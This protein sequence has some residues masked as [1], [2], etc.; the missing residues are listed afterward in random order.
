MKKILFIIQYDSFI[1]TLIPVINKLNENNFEIEIIL[2]KSKFYKKNWISNEILCLFDNIKNNTHS[3]EIL[4]IYKT[5]KKVAENEYK[6]IIIGTTYSKL[7]NKINLILKKN[8]LNSKLVSGYV[9]ALL[10][11][12]PDVFITGLKRRSHS[13]LIWTPGLDSKELIL[14]TGII[15]IKNTKV[16]DTG[17]PRFDKLYLIKDEIQSLN[18]NNIVF[19]EQPT[20]PKTKLERTYLVEKLIALAY[21]NPNNN[22]IIKPRFS[23]K[24]GHAH[25]P[26]YLIQDI[27]SKIKNKPKNIFISDEHIYEL[28]KECKLALTISSTAG[29]ES[30][31][32]NIPTLFINDFCNNIN[33]YGSEDFKKFNA[34]I[35]FDNLLSNKLPKINFKNITN[36]LRFDG[37]N[38]ERLTQEILDI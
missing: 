24:I 29:I 35:S 16:I 1:N 25:T 20:F 34:T 37:K 31:L 26:K 10:N 6:T 11:N 12:K 22:L 15:N 32:V 3:F 5:L 2:L 23:S 19:F 33:K 8:N 17:L 30:L 13:H 28:F 9:G 36:T 14:K 27:L 4:S 18:K 21:K 7:I 38:T